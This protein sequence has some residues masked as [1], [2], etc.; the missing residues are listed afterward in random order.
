MEIIN[1]VYP[2]F[3]ITG[4]PPLSKKPL[5]ASLTSRYL[6]CPWDMTRIPVNALTAEVNRANLTDS[7]P[8]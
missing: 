4:N 1:R 2:D 5:A 6:K 3:S 8:F 7:K